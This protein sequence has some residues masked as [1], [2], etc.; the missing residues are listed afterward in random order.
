MAKVECNCELRG[1]E[2]YRQV[3]FRSQLRGFWCE[4]GW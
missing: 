2:V 3:L 4:N 1:W